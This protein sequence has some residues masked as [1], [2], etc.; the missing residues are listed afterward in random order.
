M[1]HRLT[2]KRSFPT[3]RSRSKHLCAIYVELYR[4]AVLLHMSLK[5]GQVSHVDPL[6]AP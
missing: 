3:E 5:L 4:M 2:G 1:I 6:R